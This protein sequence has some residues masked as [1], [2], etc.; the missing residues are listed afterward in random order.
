[1]YFFWDFSQKKKENTHTCKK[2]QLLGEDFGTETQECRL[3]NRTLLPR[4]IYGR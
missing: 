2:K 4:L 1:M 3:K